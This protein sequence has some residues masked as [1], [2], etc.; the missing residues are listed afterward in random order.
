MDDDDVVLGPTFSKD[1]SGDGFVDEEGFT[2]TDD[3]A[4]AANEEEEEVEEEEDDSTSSERL[5]VQPDSY[6]LPPSPFS[7]TAD[8]ENRMEFF[9]REG[10]HSPTRFVASRSQKRKRRRTPH[11]PWLRRNNETSRNGNDE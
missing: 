2:T 1:G 4:A 3:N 7:I 8:K 10:N 11:S 9:G 6:E 5:V